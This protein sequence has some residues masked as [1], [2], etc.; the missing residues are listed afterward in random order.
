VTERI[1]A[2]HYSEVEDFFKLSGLWEDLCAGRLRCSI[3][4]AVITAANFQAITRREG[5]VLMSCDRQECYGSF[6]YGSPRGK[7]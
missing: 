1:G 7:E 4:G 2:V 5:V 6:P 3:C